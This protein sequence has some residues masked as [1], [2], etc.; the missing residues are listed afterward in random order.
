[1][2]RVLKI[3]NLALVDNLS[4]EIGEGLVG[5]TGETG[6][7]KSIIV[8]AVK[9]ILGERAD[10]GLIRTGCERCTVEAVFSLGPSSGIDRFLADHGFD[11][12]EDNELILKR[13]IGAKGTNKQFINCSPATLAVLRE[14][15]DQLVD[16]HG[17][18]DHQALLSCERQLAMLDAYAHA[19]EALDNYGQVYREWRA[20][21]H[22]LEELRSSERAGEQE[23][24]LLRFQ[25]GE[26]EAARLV[27]GE[28]EELERRY[29]VISNGARLAESA[30]QIADGLGAAA[31]GVLARLA[32]VQRAIAELER[33]DPAAASLTSGFASARLELEELQG[34]M[35]TYLEG[36]ELDPTEAAQL[37]QRVDLLE[38]L[39]RKY[40]N[41]AVEI[42]EFGEGAAGKLRKIEGRGDELERL[43]GAVEAARGRVERAMAALS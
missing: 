11:P 28:D 33:L 24:D 17:P 38:T 25:V 35:E 26:I 12:C 22:E 29:R 5:V 31:G 37:E 3:Q 18:H 1:M 34:G 13:V 10:R 7:G 16:L 32:Q 43:E 19:G 14:L 9:L 39:K 42:I 15:G 23:L 27:A 6:A 40:G 36:L 21:A 41:T 20:S 2:L 30:G 8:G 4:W